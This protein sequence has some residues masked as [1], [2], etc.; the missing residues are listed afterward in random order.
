MYLL[1]IDESGTSSLN[2]SNEFSSGTNGNSLYFVL[3][4][5][6]INTLELE[7]IENEVIKHKNEHMSDPFGELKT[8][9]K[10]KHLKKTSNKDEFTKGIYNIIAESNAY[11]FGT[12]INK[13]ELYK[14]NIVTSKD[15]IYQIAFEHLLN[16]VNNFLITN[17][18][19]RNVTVM[20]DNIDRAHNRKIYKCYKNAVSSRNA[21]IK[22]FNDYSFSPSIN[23]VDSEFTIGAQLADF[24]AGA[25]FRG[26]ERQD[27]E[28]AIKIHC[29]Y[30]VDNSGVVV[31][32]SHIRCKN[33]V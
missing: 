16:A 33:W 25:L 13:Y 4:G 7:V 6:L 20:I 24:V 9:I 14:K 17:K 8:T 3:G 31:G 29:R 28:N 19:N 27:K 11:I 5:V 32:Y 15:D 2:K 18:V 12:Q 10:N 30:P 26:L 22:S 1:Y 23:F 21:K